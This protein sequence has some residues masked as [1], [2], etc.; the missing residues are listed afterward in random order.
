MLG[1][2]SFVGVLIEEIACSAV[3]ALSS[4]LIMKY[5]EAFTFLCA[6]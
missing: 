5:F 3:G 1:L 6:K 2:Y 4:P